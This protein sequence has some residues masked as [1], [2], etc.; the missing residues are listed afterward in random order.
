MFDFMKSPRNKELDHGQQNAEANE[1]SA[2]ISVL[3][4]QLATRRRMAKFIRL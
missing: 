1:M 4:Q 2:E 3:E